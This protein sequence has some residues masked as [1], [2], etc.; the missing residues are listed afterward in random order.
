VSSL[1][2]AGN[3]LCSGYCA[4]L[5]HSKVRYRFHKS[6]QLIF[7]LSH[8]CPVDCHPSCFSKIHFNIIIP[9]FLCFQSGLFPSDF[10]TKILYLLLVFPKTRYVTRLSRSLNL[11]SNGITK[12]PIVLFS[13]LSCHFLALGPNVFLSSLL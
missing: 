2:A 12:P 9:F 13:P 8:I 6:P 11:N 4:C 5:C 1:R 10:P 3:T 7:I